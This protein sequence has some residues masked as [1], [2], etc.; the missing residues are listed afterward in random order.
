MTNLNS[1]AKEKMTAIQNRKGATEENEPIA[2]EQT[3]DS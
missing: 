1:L 3:D 2:E